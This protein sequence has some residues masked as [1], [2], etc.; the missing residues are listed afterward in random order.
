MFYSL[1]KN[2]EEPSSFGFAPETPGRL[3]GQGKPQFEDISIYRNPAH[4]RTL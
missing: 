2:D 3:W 1:Q 4:T